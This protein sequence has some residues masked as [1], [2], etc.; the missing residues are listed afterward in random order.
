MLSVQDD[1]YTLPIGT[2]H[3]LLLPESDRALA[4]AEAKL[5]IA[6]LVH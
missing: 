5:Q 6:S 2:Q 3:I 4:T 1:F